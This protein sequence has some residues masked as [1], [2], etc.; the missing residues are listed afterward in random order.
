MR[1]GIN[2]KIWVNSADIEADDVE[3]LAVFI[4]ERALEFL[5][6]RSGKDY[7]QCKG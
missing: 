2:R 3:D 6:A 1:N 5:P 4:L 7:L